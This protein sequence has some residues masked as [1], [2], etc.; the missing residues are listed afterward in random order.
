MGALINTLGTGYLSWFYNHEFEGNYLFHQTNAA[1]YTGNDVWGVVT[2]LYDANRQLFPL[3]PTPDPKLYP[4]LVARWQYFHTQKVLTPTNQGL[5]L[6]AI[7]DTL[8]NKA[9]TEIV[10]GVRLGANQS[11]DSTPIG[12]AQIINIVVAG[13]MAAGRDNAGKAV[14]GGPPPI[15]QR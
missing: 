4:N 6:K 10:F 14:S 12:T 2:S 11:I 13:P 3:L 8:V 5:L 15:D 1:A 9:I 7:H